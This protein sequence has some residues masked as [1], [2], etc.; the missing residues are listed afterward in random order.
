MSRHRLKTAGAKA[1]VFSSDAIQE[2][3]SF[4]NGY[5]RL[6]N[7]I[8][9]H[10]LLSGYVR[11]IIII[12]ADIIRECKE[13][14]QI[15]SL[16][17]CHNADISDNESESIHKNPAIHRVDQDPG[18]MKIR[19]RTLV[20]SI[21][22]LAVIGILAG[23]FF[24]SSITT[25][26]SANL[27]LKKGNTFNSGQGKKKDDLQ[28]SVTPVQE[29]KA[30]DVPARAKIGKVGRFPLLYSQKDPEPKLFRE[31]DSNKE[32]IPASMTF[33]RV[34]DQ[35]DRLETS[36]DDKKPEGSDA[37]TKI[38]PEESKIAEITPEKSKITPPEPEP[39][40]VQ[41]KKLEK[42]RAEPEFLEKKDLSP[43]KDRVIDNKFTSAQYE[44]QAA[45][46]KAKSFDSVPK[47]T[48][49]AVSE[50]DKQ[51]V[52]TPCNS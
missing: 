18:I 50:K 40:T 11:E 41:K 17:T 2:I 26:Y 27:A 38:V 43:Q 9:D 22:F 12:N 19:V 7:I 13:E 8:C 3:F 30:Y 14:L 1:P 28:T 51:P 29:K 36:D 21:V 52:E 15:S 4:S 37:P 35:A 24:Y 42:D 45:R 44:K 20:I 34:A 16:N 10:A 32:E 48:I 33:E 46:L 49:A 25:K 6:I 31:I 47:P 23:Y 5:P 39:V